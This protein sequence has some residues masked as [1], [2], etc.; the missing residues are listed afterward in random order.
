MR[1]RRSNNYNKMKTLD[2]DKDTEIKKMTKNKKGM[3]AKNKEIKEK[4]KQKNRKR[5]R[6]AIK[7]SE[8]IE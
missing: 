4:G 2:D 7:Q 3:K 8:N 5:K 6:N 1:Q